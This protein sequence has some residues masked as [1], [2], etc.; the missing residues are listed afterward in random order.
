MMKRWTILLAA[1]SVVAAACGDGGDDDAAATRSPEAE[2]T[3]TV[4]ATTEAPDD[5]SGNGGDSEAEE[6]DAG[7]VEL[8]FEI[9]VLG[10][11]WPTDWS[12]S[13]I[14]LE[15][16][17]VGIAAQDPRD[18]IRPI[19]DPV[20]EDVASADAW[21]ED[22]EIGILLEVEGEAIFY[23]VRILI[24]HEIV[25]DQ[26]GEVPFSLTYCPLC[27]TAS[28]FDRRVDGQVLRFGVSGLLRNSD[29]VMWDDATVSLWQQATG[30][31]IVGD[32]AGTQLEF[33]PTAL[34]RWADFRDNN[35][36]GDVLSIESGPF[37][38]G[39]NAYFGY[40]SRSA[41]YGRFFTEEL[42]DRYDALSRVVGVRVDGTTKAY[43][44]ETIAGERAVND[45]VNGVP[46]AVWWGAPDTADPLDAGTI[47]GGAAI[48]TGV[49]YD[50]RIDG[51]VLTFAAQG[52]SD[53]FVDAETGT[54]WNLLGVAIDGPL[55]GQELDSIIHM[56]EFW[57]AW[58][59]FNEGAPVYGE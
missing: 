15:E 56:N 34:I 33:L 31:G 21:L 40:T 16:L 24:S 57:F 43:P 1:L 30:E 7:Q 46:L 9:N 28:A 38:Y 59:A 23:P 51:Q 29:L 32:F 44:F 41:P 5:T 52:D 17:R 25:N 12:M 58:A 54:T 4:A 50:R 48:G 26:R 35:P 53:T 47:A 19:D 14:D 39:T 8:P 6:G 45:E 37:D 20:Y 42:D 27:N 36:D 18:L 22:Q 2:T 55:A 10:A 11:V 13:T 49:A 3:T